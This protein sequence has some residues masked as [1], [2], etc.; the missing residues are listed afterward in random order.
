MGSIECSQNVSLY[1]LNAY[2]IFLFFFF[3]TSLLILHPSSR[4]S[5]S[6]VVTGN[7]FLMTLNFTPVVTGACFLRGPLARRFLN[8]YCSVKYTV[9][10]V[11]GI[12]KFNNNPAIKY[13]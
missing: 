6:P 8:F 5:F 4:Y 11:R 12:F 7:V 9:C 1:A 13:L 10:F 3:E 2:L